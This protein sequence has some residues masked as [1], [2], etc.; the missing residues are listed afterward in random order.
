[1][2]IGD[3]LKS[4][5]LN[6]AEIGQTPKILTIKSVGTKELGDDK[7]EKI[8]LS[9]FE[10]TKSLPLNKTRLRFMA[11]TFGLETQLWINAR[12]M[13]YGQRLSNGKYSGQW[14]ILMTTVPN[15]GPAVQATPA[16]LVEEPF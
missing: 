14:T 1:M 13:V 11:E 7:E 15:S 16:Q 5:Y 3:Y 12:V 8:I 4:D 9:F 10:E 2:N 6:G